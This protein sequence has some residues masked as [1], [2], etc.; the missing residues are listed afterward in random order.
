MSKPYPTPHELKL[1]YA[2]RETAVACLAAKGSIGAAD[3][4]ALDRLGRCKVAN[5]HWGLCD[6]AARHSLL[7][8][9]HHF[10]RSCASLAA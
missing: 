7:N 5:E 2:E 6:E 4:Q 1:L 8:D 3:L 10:V 9:S